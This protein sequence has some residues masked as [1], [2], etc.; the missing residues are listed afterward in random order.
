MDEAPL[1]YVAVVDPEC[2]KNSNLRARST[3]TE[4]FNMRKGPK[5]HAVWANV[6]ERRSLPASMENLRN[7][8][9]EDPCLLGLSPNRE[10]RLNL[11]RED[12]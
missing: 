8:V 9:E 5:G 12:F 1:G 7:E 2:L 4:R 11:V 10:Y 6:I 3:F